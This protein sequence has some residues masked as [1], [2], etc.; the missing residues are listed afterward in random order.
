MR[1]YSL[2]KTGRDLKVIATFRNSPYYEAVKNAKNG[3]FID[4]A[5]HKIRV[6]YNQEYDVIEEARASNIGIRVIDYKITDV[7]EIVEEVEKWALYL[8]KC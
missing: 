2:I 7:K 8:K 6:I 5:N 1:K 3:C 4:I